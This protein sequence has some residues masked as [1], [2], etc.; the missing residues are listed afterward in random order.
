MPKKVNPEYEWL[1][2]I[3]DTVKTAFALEMSEATA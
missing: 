1:A 3:V 2:K